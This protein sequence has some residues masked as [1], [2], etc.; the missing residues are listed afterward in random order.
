MPGG[1]CEQWHWG[2]QPVKGPEQWRQGWAGDGG[3]A[4]AARAETGDGEPGH[5][6]RC[7]GH[8]DG[9]REFGSCGRVRGFPSHRASSVGWT[10]SNAGVGGRRDTCVEDQGPVWRARA[11]RGAQGRRGLDEKRKRKRSGLGGS[12]GAPALPSGFSRRPANVS[13]KRIDFNPA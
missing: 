9:G 6:T 7:A 4:A 8:H 3:C 2:S 1:G 12:F 13:R 11:A 5:D 10:G